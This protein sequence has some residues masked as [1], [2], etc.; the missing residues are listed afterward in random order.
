MCSL[1]KQLNSTSFVVV[2]KDNTSSSGI[3]VTLDDDGQKGSEH[4]GS[5]ECIRPHHSFDATL[6][7]EGFNKTSQTFEAF[8]LLTM[9]V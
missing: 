6:S 5:L 7:E 8:H 3:I 2:V 9:V 4:H 1:L